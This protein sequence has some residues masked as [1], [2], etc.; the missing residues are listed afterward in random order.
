MPIQ[1]SKETLYLV[2]TVLFITFLIVSDLIGGKTITLNLNTIQF[3]NFTLKPIFSAGLLPFA[4]T[5]VITDIVNEFFGIRGAKKLT[6]LGLLASMI[7]ISI[8]YIAIHLPTYDNSIISDITF[9]SVFGISS[10][11]FLGSLIAYIC[12]Q[13]LDIYVFQYIKGIT[14]NR[15][16]WLRMTGSTVV[17]QIIDCLI[18]N[19]IAYAGL[20][21]WDDIL[22]IAINNYGIKLIIA[23]VLTPICY[24]L[25]DII[26]A[27]YIKYGI[28]QPKV[29]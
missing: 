27:Q 9:K 5:F 25:H 24:V 4:F 29:I 14:G 3:D 16:I 21:I 15:F 8:L 10:R 20:M 26:Q 6:L 13:L 18:V 17:S 2:L 23:I 7:T 22:S 12:G 11:I 19:I 1:K 28:Q